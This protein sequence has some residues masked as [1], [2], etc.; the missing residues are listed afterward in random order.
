MGKNSMKFAALIS[1]AVLLS[2]VTLTGCTPQ[3]D[4]ASTPTA[5]T[6]E[7]E[8]PNPPVEET[9][10]WECETRED[11]LG[12]TFAC[13]S[14]A[15]DSDGTY[16][17]FTLMCTSDKRALNSILGMRADTSFIEWDTSVSN[18]AKVSVDS[19]SIQEWRYQTKGATAF[20]FSTLAGNGK[21]EEAST[22]DLLGRL[23]SVETFGFK[24]F[25]SEGISRSARFEVQGSVPIAAK[26]SALGC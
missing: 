2:M 6:I 17:V 16:W 4:S 18:K 19:G 12:D 5:T 24:A 26:F 3:G 10:A 11:G 14:N 23:A 21:S 1:T 15:K 25:D 13:Q 22:W 9:S 20:T 7:T 8:L